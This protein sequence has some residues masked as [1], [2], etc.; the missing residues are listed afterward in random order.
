MWQTRSHAQPQWDLRQHHGWISR[1]NAQDH[2]ALNFRP[3]STQSSPPAAT[4]PSAT[5]TQCLL[6]PSWRHG[7]ATIDP[8]C[9]VWQNATGKHLPPAN[10]HGHAGVSTQPR[11]DDEC[12]TVPA[13][14]RKY[15]NVADGP[16]ADGRTHVDESLCPQP[17]A[18]PDA[19]KILTSRG[20]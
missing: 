5:S 15:A 20:G 18:Q 1:P 11:N 13:G 12:L 16:T 10:D 9:T 19:G 17:A 8:S 3:H 2:L 4:A 14:R 6:L 7:L